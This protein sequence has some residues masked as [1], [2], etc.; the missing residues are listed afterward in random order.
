MLPATAILLGAVV[1]P[2]D[3]VLA[4]GIE[5]GAPLT[6]IEEEEAPEHRWGTV[7]FSLTSEAGLNDGLAFPLTYLAIAAAG[8]PAAAGYG[9]LAEW[10]AVDVV[11]RIAVGVAIGYVVGMVMARLIFRLP[12][13]EGLTDVMAGAEALATTL[14]AY[15]VTEL[16]AGYGF[17]AGFVAALVLRR[18]E[19][20]HEYYRELHDFA[21]VVERLLLAVVLVLFGGALAGGL[22]VPLTTTE[23]LLGV[24][25]VLIVR[26]IAG[27]LAFVGSDA[28]LPDRLVISFFGIRGIGSFYYLAF[29]L[30]HSTFDELELII[31]APRLW[32]F[33]GFTVVLSIGL[34]GVTATPVMSAYERWRERI[35]RPVVEDDP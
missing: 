27:A 8:A 13:T 32:A 9:W 16:A 12:A 1:A 21:V 25:V 35:G 18:F 28:A 5:A 3:P 2:T 31:E 33:V 15:A 14:V 22:L 23:V 34:H 17:I 10:L 7:R 19:W 29:A 6:E 24:V 4:S 30:A 26:P 20:E 11:Y